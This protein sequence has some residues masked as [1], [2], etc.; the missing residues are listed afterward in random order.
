[1]TTN[2]ADRAQSGVPKRPYQTPRLDV[3][4]DIREV[5]DSVGMKSMKADGATGMNTKT[6]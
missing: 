1:M 3:Y 4:G 5:T 2:N 6:A